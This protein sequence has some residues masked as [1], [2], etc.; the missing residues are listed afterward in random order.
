MNCLDAETLAAWMD[1]GLT[2]AALAEVQAHVAGC[3]RCQMLLGAMGR[4]RAAVPS[5][6]QERAPRRWLA[7]A[8]PLAAAATAI[9][10]WVAIPEQRSAP[11]VVPV[12]T[13]PSRTEQPAT[14]VPPVAQPPAAPAPPGIVR[15]QIPATSA[16]T[17]PA[18]QDE[19]PVPST[20]EAE[21]LQKTDALTPSAPATNAPQKQESQADAQAAPAAAAAPSS[22]QSAEVRQRASRAVIAG[23]IAVNA[24]AGATIGMLCGPKWTS[25]PADATGRMT[26][27]SSPSATVCWVV[28]RGGL[29]RRSTDGQSWEPIPFPDMTDLSG[30]QASDARAATVTTAS[31]RSFSTSDGGRTWR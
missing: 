3:D 28:G 14:Q 10:V 24:L 18:R 9:A 7:W 11:P 4:T 27:G 17:S 8:V 31:G 19:A 6:L 21:R 13:S 22:S 2:G 1:G 15:P 5:S 23:N 30:V 16:P 12:T 26:A 29:I 25:A 20:P